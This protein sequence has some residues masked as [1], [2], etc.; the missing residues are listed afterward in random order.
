MCVCVCV[1][2][3]G[4]RWVLYLKI[5]KV[6]QSVLEPTN[7][8]LSVYEQNTKY[9]SICSFLLMFLRIV[10]LKFSHVSDDGSEIDSKYNICSS[11]VIII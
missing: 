1:C 7:P 9:F 5:A 6:V 4:C 11:F 2:V 3:G 10:F 8:Y